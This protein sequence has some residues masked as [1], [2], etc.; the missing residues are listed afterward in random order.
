MRVETF[1]AAVGVGGQHESRHLC[2]DLRETAV[3]LSEE[4]REAG[5]M[6]VHGG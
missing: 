3:G 6:G 2:S 1:G 4:G 5:E